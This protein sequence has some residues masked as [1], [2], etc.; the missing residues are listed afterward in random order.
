MS[1]LH[2]DG[3]LE[4][5]DLSCNGYHKHCREFWAPWAPVSTLGTRLLHNA[6]IFSVD[7]AAVETDPPPFFSFWQ[8]PAASHGEKILSM[9]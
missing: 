3:T 9:I 5:G 6:H 8:G 4:R 2:W 1:G 7:S